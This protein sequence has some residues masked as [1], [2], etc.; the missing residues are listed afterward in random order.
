MIRAAQLFAIFAMLPA[1]CGPV[2]GREPTIDLALCGGG[3][4]T[5]PLGGAPAAPAGEPCCAKG[6]H[7]QRKRTRSE[8]AD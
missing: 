4:I 6:C 8:P 5:V 7:N 2:A 1:M 3:V